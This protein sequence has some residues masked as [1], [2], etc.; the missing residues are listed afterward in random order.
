[1]NTDMVLQAEVTLESLATKF[2]FYIPFTEVNHKMTFQCRLVDKS[3]FAIRTGVVSFLGMFSIVT[4]QLER[5]LERDVAQ[6][7]W[8]LPSE[9]C[10]RRAYNEQL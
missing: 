5:S 6:I 3:L 2:T 4:L 7:T 10:I 8:I 1:M 9:K